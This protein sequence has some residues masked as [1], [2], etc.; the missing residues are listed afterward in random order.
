MEPSDLQHRFAFHK[1]NEVTTPIHEQIRNTLNATAQELNQVV[2]DG[3]EKSL[4]ITHL[5]EAM[6]WANAGVARSQG[7]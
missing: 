6:M 5:E 2:P 4:M 1:A 3:R 7:G